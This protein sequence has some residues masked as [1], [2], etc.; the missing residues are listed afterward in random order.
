[1][2]TYFH[3]PD[4]FTKNVEASHS[5]ELQRNVCTE[6]VVCYKKDGAKKH[7]CFMLNLF[8]IQIF[9][10]RSALNEPV[11]FY[12]FGVTFGMPGQSMLIYPS[13]HYNSDFTKYHS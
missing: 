9:D 1:M 11:T 5:P 8:F 3:L 12:F 13:Y 10:V 2:D 4:Y 7:F 6:R